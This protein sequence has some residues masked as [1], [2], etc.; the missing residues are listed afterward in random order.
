MNGTITNGN[1][2]TNADVS[3]SEIQELQT[4]KNF[5]LGKIVQWHKLGRYDI[6]EYH[7][8]DFSRH[9]MDTNTTHFVSWIDGHN[10]GW[11][12]HTLERAIVGSIAIAYDGSNTQAGEF[13][14]RMVN[15][16][17]V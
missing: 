14:A 3:V 15:L 16:P 2:A 11:G 13:F 8:I 12:W 1:I 7:P 6:A 5:W 9:V 10:S 17:Q 4:G